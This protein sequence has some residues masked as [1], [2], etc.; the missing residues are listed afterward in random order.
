MWR[1]V[2]VSVI[3]PHDVGLCELDANGKNN[4]DVAID[5]ENNDVAAFELRSSDTLAVF[6][7]RA[8]GVEGKNFHGLPFV[9]TV[10]ALPARE[11][12]V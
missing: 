5:V 10:F 11:I 3:S 9:Y 6:G 12:R 7:I 8:T 1:G 4:V 2:H